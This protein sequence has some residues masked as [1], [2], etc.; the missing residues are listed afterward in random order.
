MA[1][2][3][4]YIAMYLAVALV[5]VVIGAFTEFIRIY[6]FLVSPHRVYRVPH[7]IVPVVSSKRPAS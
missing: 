3:W 1:D 4:F 2:T 6:S 7:V 5:I